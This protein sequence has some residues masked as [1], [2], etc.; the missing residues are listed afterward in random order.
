MEDIDLAII[1]FIFISISVTQFFIL[2]R[3]KKV[4]KFL[5]PQSFI[6]KK[7]RLEKE[8]ESSW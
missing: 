7:E 1:L 8:Q 4:H 3:L 2:R 5:D 6:T